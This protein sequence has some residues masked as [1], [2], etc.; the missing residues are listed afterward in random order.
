MAHEPGDEKGQRPRIIA[1]ETNGLTTYNPPACLSD[2]SPV[3][4]MPKRSEQAFYT[5][6]SLSAMKA[7]MLG[8]KFEGAHEQKELCLSPR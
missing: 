4:P 1:N 3:K 8:P 2:A 5:V 6:S 7:A